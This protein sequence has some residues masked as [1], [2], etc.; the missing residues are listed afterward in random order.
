MSTELIPQVLTELGIF[1]EKNLGG[2][3]EFEYCKWKRPSIDHREVEMHADYL[4][5]GLMCQ[6]KG[7]LIRVFNPKNRSE[8][9]ELANEFNSV[10]RFSNIVVG[11]NQRVGPG[12]GFVV[13]SKF[14]F[15]LEKTPSSTYIA[16]TIENVH[17]GI[18]DF[19][20]KILEYVDLVPLEKY[21]DE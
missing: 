15:A 11:H 6:F 18:G 12:F 16:E 3:F 10:S 17:R 19:Y 21:E 4:P 1:F 5:G 20:S 13:C 14:L 7:I 2:D 9:L 8:V